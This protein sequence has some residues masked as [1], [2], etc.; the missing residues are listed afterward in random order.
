[1][2]ELVYLVT[3]CELRSSY[4]H[5]KLGKLCAEFLGCFNKD[6]P[7]RISSLAGIA[8]TTGLCDYYAIR[9]QHRIRLPTYASHLRCGRY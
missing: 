4:G 9:H 3:A 2:V 5:L 1:M 7:C 6:G 8:L